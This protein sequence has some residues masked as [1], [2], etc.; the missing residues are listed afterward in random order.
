MN[1]SRGPKL[2]NWVADFETTTKEDDC[3]VWGWGFASI[4]QIGRVETGT[5]IDSFFDRIK[6]LDLTVYFHN[7]GFDGIFILDRLFR[8]GYTHHEEGRLKPGTFDTLISNMGKFYSITVNWEDGGKTVFK[9]SLKK[10]PMSVAAIADAFNM[11]IGKGD[12]DYHAERPVG[13]VLTPEEISYIERDVLIVARALK[14]Q[15]D[16]GMTK[17]TVGADSLAE[18]KRITGGKVFTR[19]FPIL[20]DSMDAEIRRAYRGGFTYADERF[21]GKKLG[22]GR[23]YDVNSLYPSVMYDRVLP[24]GE[25]VFEPGLPKATKEYPLFIVS[26]T[27]TAKLKKNHIPCIQVKGSSF[28]L[29]T[30]YQKEIKEPVTLMATNVDLALWQD[31]YDMNIMSFNGGWL[32][33]GAQGLFNEYIDKWMEV[34]ARHHGGLRVIAKLHL[35]SL[36]GK[37]ATNPDVTGKVPVFE[38]NVVKLKTGPEATRDPVYT[39][40]GV[41]ITAYARDVTV[42]A[43]QVHYDVFAYADTDSLHLLV[44]DDPETLD[45]DP[46]RL[47]AWKRETIFQSA[48]FM[49]AKAYTELDMDGNYST[50][51][52]GL[53]VS[54]AKR[55]TFESLQ[56]GAV[57]D[58][59]LHPKRVPGGVVLQDVG[60]TLKF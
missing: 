38:D 32:F 26:V 8:M 14:I 39:P 22:R 24:Y 27:F 20:P 47:G 28:F 11:D 53:P 4:D 13:H 1:L 59:K 37:F 2:K 48:I 52:A 36:Y 46:V 18:Y 50:H 16:S 42:R 34:K 23:V 33:K 3:R 15:L 17:L 41:F 55:V 12:I 19:I 25:P 44:E 5:D 40:M 45:I 51:I 6:E 58:G 30:E 56:D 7:L 35:N 57:F 31:Q 54:V 10:L 9:D 49:R 29:N 43:A 60:F 21:K